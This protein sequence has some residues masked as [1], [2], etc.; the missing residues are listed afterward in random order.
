VRNEYIRLK[1]QYI[2][3]GSIGRPSLLK[4]DPH[5]VNNLRAAFLIGCTKHQA[6]IYAGISYK[7]LYT[8]LK[9]DEELL[10]QV[11]GWQQEPT[12]KAKRTVIQNIEADVN[13]A[14]W[15]LERTSPEEFGIRSKIQADITAKKAPMTEEELTKLKQEMADSL[16]TDINNGIFKDSPKPL[17][18]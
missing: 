1:T 18:D 4:T 10:Q 16:G 13:T 15:W 6:A 2:I 8:Y 11:Q 5:L 12:L 9:N 14:K 3:K 17:S 7:T